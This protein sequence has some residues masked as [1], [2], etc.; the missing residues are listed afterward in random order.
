MGFYLAAIRWVDE[1]LK[2]VREM[3]DRRG[4]LE[5]TVLVLA[6]DH[7]EAFGENQTYGHAVNVHSPVLRVPL[8]IRLPFDAPARRVPTQVRNV[9][10]APTL[11]ELA[12]API[13]ES[14]EGASLV[15]LMSGPEPEEDRPSYASLKAH[16]VRSSKLQIAVND[17][18]WTLV[19][20]LEGDQEERLFDLAVDPREDANLTDLEP[21]R[22][23][24]MRQMLDAHEQVGARAGVKRKEVRID[25]A[26]AER[27]RAVGYLQ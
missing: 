4:M 20:N 6:S 7:G 26:I 11:L 27:L 10:I 25:P 22:A 21:D 24:P 23:E 17:G 1:A 3:L 18:S 16:I 8:V 2:H 19:R 15:P 9:D 14:F 5:D 12:G 13:P